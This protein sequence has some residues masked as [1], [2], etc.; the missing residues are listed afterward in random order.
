MNGHDVSEPIIHP[1]DIWTGPLDRETPAMSA[2]GSGAGGA[3]GGGYLEYLTSV[4][5][6]FASYMRL[7]LIASS[8]VAAVLSSLLYFKQK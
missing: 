3:G 7:P 5:G 6:S 8:G 1:E 2:Q 4:A